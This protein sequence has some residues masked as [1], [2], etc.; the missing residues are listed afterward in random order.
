MYRPRK[1]DSRTV[2]RA[3]VGV[4]ILDK[5]GRILLEKRSDCGFWGIPGGSVEPGESVAQTAV[6]EIKEETGLTVRVTGLFGVYSA[7]KCRLVTYPERVVQLVDSI[8]EA[9]IVRGRLKC[10]HESEELAFF[11]LDRLP[12]AVVPPALEVLRDVRK[13]RKGVLR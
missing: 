3:G 13:G 8:V 1:A 5:E 10:S 6:R 11:P 9:K 7:A 2:V 4:I 12:K